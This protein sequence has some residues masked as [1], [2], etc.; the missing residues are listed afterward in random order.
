MNDKTAILRRMVDICFAVKIAS[1][2]GQSLGKVQLQKFI[3]LLDVLKPVYEIMPPLDGHLTYK[4]GPYDV[5]I[6]N[7][8]D[9]LAFRGFLKFHQIKRNSQN[10]VALTYNMT[11]AGESWVKKLNSNRDFLSNWDLAL[12]IGY[13][14]NK[15]GWGRIIDLVYSEPTFVSIR[16]KGFGQ[17]IISYDATQNSAALIMAIIDFGLTAGFERS[18]INNDLMVKLFFEYLDSADKNAHKWSALKLEVL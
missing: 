15:L 18:F 4:Y 2:Y 13:W 16:Q 12:K 3:Y 6:Q 1:N 17:R 5:K 9:V 11:P 7:A 10:Q 14:L 8:A